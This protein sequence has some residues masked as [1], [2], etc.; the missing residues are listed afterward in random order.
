M[1]MYFVLCNGHERQELVIYA[2]TEEDAI[3]EAQRRLD[4]RFTKAWNMKAVS[5]RLIRKE[6]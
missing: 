3:S 5:A 6:N 2:R 4:K 1:N